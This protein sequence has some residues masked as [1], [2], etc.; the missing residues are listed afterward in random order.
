[1][2]KDRGN[3]RRQLQDQVF[4]KAEASQRGME[5]GIAGLVIAVCHL[6]SL[7]LER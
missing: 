7:A 6:L 1:M 3:A 5:G 4:E 2:Q